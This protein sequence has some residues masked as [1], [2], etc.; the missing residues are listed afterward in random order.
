MFAGATI[1]GALIGSRTHVKIKEEYVKA[2][3]IA[4]LIVAA[5]WMVIKTL[6]K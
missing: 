6:F 2:G 3:F 5:I 4:I 1:A